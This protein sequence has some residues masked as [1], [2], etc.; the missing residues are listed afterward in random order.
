[1]L[2]VPYGS[3]RV[4]PQPALFFT[5]KVGA[6]ISFVW[7]ARVWAWFLALGLFAFGFWLLAFRFWLFWRFCIG[8]WGAWDLG[9]WV[10]GV[11]ASAF[12]LQCLSFSVW[13]SAFG[14]VFGLFTFGLLALGLLA[15]AKQNDR[16]AECHC[17]LAVVL[18]AVAL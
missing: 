17:A 3:R 10:L 13:A 7:C 2:D 5:F 15:F 18:L 6:L 14:Q 4:L 9:V 12:G 1:M 11:W 16:G 8:R